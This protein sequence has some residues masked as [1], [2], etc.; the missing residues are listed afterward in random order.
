MKTFGFAGLPKVLTTSA[1]PFYP[2]ST[3]GC[4]TSLHRAACHVIRERGD[5]MSLGRGLE[6]SS[7]NVWRTL[8][9]RL[10]GASRVLGRAA[11]LGER[12]LLL[13][14][15]EEQW[16]CGWFDLYHYRWLPQSRAT[17]LGERWLLWGA[18]GKEDWGS[19]DWWPFLDSM[20]GLDLAFEPGFGLLEEVGADG[21][22]S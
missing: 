17:S 5:C 20:C 18:W 3:P 10:M 13:G 6:E 21:A 11:S 4:S 9:S 8:R 15:L 2:R 19:F 1:T 22:G 16:W 14:S 12:W 7:D